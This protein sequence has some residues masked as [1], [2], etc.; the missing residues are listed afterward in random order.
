[1]HLV[2]LTKE[3]YYDAQTY[4]HQNTPSCLNTNFSAN[5]LHRWVSQAVEEYVVLK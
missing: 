3:I 5:F 1:M 2:G 4:E